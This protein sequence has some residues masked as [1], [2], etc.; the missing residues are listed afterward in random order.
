MNFVKKLTILMLTVFGCSNKPSIEE[1]QKF[2]AVEEYPEDTYLDT[3]TNKKAMI[4]VAHDDDDC[5]MSG[6]ISKLTKSGWEIQQVSFVTT[7]LKEGQ[8]E[9]PSTII[10]TGNTPVLE[11]GDYRIGL[12]TMQFPYKPIPKSQ[13]E[14]EFKKDKIIESLRSK[15]NTF[16]PSVIFTMDNE[17]G[18]Y[19]HPEHVFISQTVLDIF[20]DSL[21]DVE[22]IYQGVYTNHMEKEIIETWLYNRMKEYKFPNPY[23]LGKAVYNVSGMPEP[24]V[25]INIAA[26]ASDKIAYLMAYHNDARKNMRKFIPYFEEFDTKTY[27]SVFDREFFRVIER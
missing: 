7:Q 27:F 16:K 15:I 8:K 14:K 5:F 2:A 11:D 21:I 22:R 1:L 13:M 4:I 12:D 3:V 23:M 20:S 24:N 17:I 10:C 25:Q 19:G 26:Q 6:T 9:H 18:G